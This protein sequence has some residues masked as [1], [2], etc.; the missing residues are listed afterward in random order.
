MKMISISD[1]FDIT[2]SKSFDLNRMNKIKNGIN[3]VGR[4]RNCNG[5]TAK[6]E[7]ND[8]EPNLGNCITVPMVGASTLFC[9]YQDKAFYASQNIAILRPI[10]DGIGK[11]EC[12]YYML[13]LK[14]N[15]YKFSYGRTLNISMLKKIKVPY[16]CDI[17]SWVN[18]IDM[19]KYD[20]INLPYHNN[21]VR[22]SNV[23]DW[24][25][26]KLND[27][28]N[29]SGSKTTPIKQLK[30]TGDGEYPY[31][32][33]QATNNGIGGFFNYYTEKGNVLTI[34]SA[35]LGYCSYQGIDFSASDHVEKLVPK[36]KLNK[37]IALFLCTIINKEQYRF[38]YGRKCSQARMNKMKIKLPSKNGEPDWEFMENYIKSLPY[39]KSI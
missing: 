7:K 39:S 38:N 22:L 9:S 18:E 11:K 26:F 37:Y 30:I 3:Y 10:L 17:P 14:S 21:E 23:K 1:I 2:I 8:F 34:D 12:F 4:T 20:N 36:F 5:I 32:T 35:V 33:T 6:V 28:F 27:I 29:I 24:R 19:S 25:Y 16:L 31:V 15:R 13:I